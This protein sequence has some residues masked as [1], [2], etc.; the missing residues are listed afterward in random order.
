MDA[1]YTIV[2]FMVMLVAT[3]C[4]AEIINIYFETKGEE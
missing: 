2:W 1:I 4:A 3:V